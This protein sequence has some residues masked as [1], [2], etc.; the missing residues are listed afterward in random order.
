MTM[1]LGM[2]PHPPDIILACEDGDV[3]WNLQNPSKELDTA[4]SPV[5]PALEWFS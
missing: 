5:I 3:L 2:L 1:S 4:A